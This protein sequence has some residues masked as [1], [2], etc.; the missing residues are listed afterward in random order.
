MD[1]AGYS[2]EIQEVEVGRRVRRGLSHANATQFLCDMA[3]KCLSEKAYRAACTC[4]ILHC[5]C[6]K[7]VCV[8]AVRWALQGTCPGCS[9]ASHCRSSGIGSSN[10]TLCI[11]IV[12]KELIIEMVRWTSNLYAHGSGR[13]NDGWI[14]GIEGTVSQGASFLFK[15]QVVTHKSVFSIRSGDSPHLWDLALLFCVFFLQHKH[16]E[17]FVANQ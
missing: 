8:S 4:I 12:I 15:I 1:I 11:K 2:Q 6:F 5:H 3:R 17:V 16:T 13:E 7:H 10:P 9:T 14:D